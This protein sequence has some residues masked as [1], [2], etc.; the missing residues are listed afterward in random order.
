[1]LYLLTDRIYNKY[2]PKVP[3]RLKGN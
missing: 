3:Y 2:M 1:V